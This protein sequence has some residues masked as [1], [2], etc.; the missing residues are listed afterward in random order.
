MGGACSRWYRQITQYIGGE[1]NAMVLSDAV[2]NARVTRR[3]VVDVSALDRVRL[4]I[5]DD[6]D[7]GRDPGGRLLRACVDLVGVTGAGITFGL[8]RIQGLS[9]GGTDDAIRLVED[10]QFTL[11]VGPCVDTWTTGR[12]VSEPHLADPEVARWPGLAGPAVAAGVQA[13]FGFPIVEGG[14]PIG[15]LDLYCDEPGSLSATQISDALIMADVIAETILGLQTDTMPGV[16]AGAFDH[17]AR[18]RS[19]VH[20]AS[21]ML[22]VQL[23]VTVQVALLRL[24]AH[25]YACGETIDNVAAAVVEHGLRIDHQAAEGAL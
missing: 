11:G 21:G 16:L 25:A 17:P 9:L 5:A 19:V 23:D 4:G 12:P 15:A 8:D 24:R 20:Q 13:L 14:I 7:A 3:P 1:T 2:D 6:R 22:S 18:L 10:L